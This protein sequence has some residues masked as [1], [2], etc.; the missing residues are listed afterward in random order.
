[1][2]PLNVMYGGITHE[3]S[4]KRAMTYQ[5]NGYPAGRWRLPTE[6]EIAFIVARQKEGVIPWLFASTYY[7]CANGRL[8]Y[9]LTGND[10]RNDPPIS[11]NSSRAGFNRFVYDLWY[12]GEEPMDPNV[13]H[14]NMHEH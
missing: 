5:E 6:A 3:S 12:W 2:S 10:H 7:H 11:L 14:A 4:V 8:M 13:Y 9:V 1:S